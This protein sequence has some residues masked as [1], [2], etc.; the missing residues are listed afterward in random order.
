MKYMKDI[1]VDFN[2]KEYLQGHFDEDD[3]DFKLNDNN[4]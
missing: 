3:D 2:N 4:Q 1:N